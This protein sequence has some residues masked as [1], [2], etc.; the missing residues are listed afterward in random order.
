MDKRN[1]YVKGISFDSST[2]RAV[3]RQALAEGRSRSGLVRQAIRF[4]IAS[5]SAQQAALPGLIGE[6]N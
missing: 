2:L 6:K 3:D 1:L 4:Y 5:K